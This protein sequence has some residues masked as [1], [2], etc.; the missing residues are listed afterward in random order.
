MQ[1]LVLVSC[2]SLDLQIICKVG[3]MLIFVNVTNRDLLIMEV[4]IYVY[5][6]FC[7]LFWYIYIHIFTQEEISVMT[8]SDQFG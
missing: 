1:G 7:Y 5:I 8:F 2:D 3:V 4:L 6:K